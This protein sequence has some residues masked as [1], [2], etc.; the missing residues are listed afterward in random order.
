MVNNNE[1]KLA[2]WYEQGSPEE[3]NY[4]ISRHSSARQENV[5]KGV[6]VYQ[7]YPI[8]EKNADLLLYQMVKDLVLHPNFKDYLS[9]INLGGTSINFNY[10]NGE[11]E[12]WFR[13]YLLFPSDDRITAYYKEEL[14]WPYMVGASSIYYHAY[15]ESGII[16]EDDHPQFRVYYTVRWDHRLEGS[17]V[18]YVEFFRREEH[19]MPVMEDNTLKLQEIICNVLNLMPEDKTC[20][21][22]WKQRLTSALKMLVT[23]ANELHILHQA[24]LYDIGELKTILRQEG[25]EGDQLDAMIDKMIKELHRYAMLVVNL[26]DWQLTGFD[27]S[28]VTK[29]IPKHKVINDSIQNDNFV[30]KKSEKPIEVERTPDYEYNRYNNVKTHHFDNN[31]DSKGYDWDNVW[32]KYPFERDNMDPDEYE[33]KRR[34]WLWENSR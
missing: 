7:L 22:P 11:S 31:Q 12:E 4:F 6:C 27:T 33:A 2:L 1:K 5:L 20:L 13:P 16:E 15:G 24:G 32:P 30:Y 19:R 34:A 26:I 28:K 3:G 9:A 17:V 21:T 18:K 25:K 10:A 29:C 14:K 8:L 23:N